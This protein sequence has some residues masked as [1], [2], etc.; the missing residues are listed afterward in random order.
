MYFLKPLLNKPRAYV[1]V[2][3][4]KVHYRLESV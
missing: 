1:K 4:K 3:Y 2:F